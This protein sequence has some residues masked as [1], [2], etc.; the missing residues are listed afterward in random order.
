LWTRKEALVKAGAA[1][2]D[3]LADVDLIETGPRPATRFAGR[4][5]VEKLIGTT[6][7]ANVSGG[8]T[9]VATLARALPGWP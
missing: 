2:L 7:H 8:G 6:D 5:L 1:N 9:V 4:E 3:R